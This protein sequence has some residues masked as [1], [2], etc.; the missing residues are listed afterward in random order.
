MPDL[1]EP[2][3]G[4]RFAPRGPFAVERCAEQPPLAPVGER[5]VA[6][7]WRAPLDTLLEIG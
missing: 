1:R 7:C 6:A 5:H 2:P 3:P 4:C